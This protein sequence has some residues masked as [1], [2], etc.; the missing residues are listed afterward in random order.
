M[1]STKVV[2]TGAAGFI[3][4]HLVDELLRGGHHVVGFDDFDPWYSPRAKHH[5]LAAATRSPR[6]ELRAEAVSAEPLASAL[7]GAAA[8]FHLAGRP[9]VQS[10]WGDGFGECVRRNVDLAQAVL[11]VA[12]RAATPAV[13]LAS[14]SSVYGA[15]GTTD[16]PTPTSPYG[17]SKLAVE[18][19]ARIYADEGVPITALRYFTVYGPR[20]RPDMAL[21]RL[22]EAARPGGPPF[23]R[24]GNGHQRREMTFVDDVV[25]ATLAAWRAGPRGEVLDVGGGSSATLNELIA[26]VASVAGHPIELIAEPAASGDPEI[27]VADLEPTRRALGWSPRWTLRSGLVEQRRWHDQPSTDIARRSAPSALAG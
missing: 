11:D 5:N 15:T 21:H 23:R 18:H 27:T 2:V 16:R 20:Q 12:L 25:A 10:S 8:L 6:F 14:S 7:D 3:G 26:E 13:V 24:R 4:S 9:G 19:L 22:F 17:V 1:R